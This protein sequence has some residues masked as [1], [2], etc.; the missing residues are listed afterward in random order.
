M[1][2]LASIC[3][4]SFIIFNGCKKEEP[5]PE[6]VATYEAIYKVTSSSVGTTSYNVIEYLDS[7]GDTVRSFNTNEGIEIRFPISNK[8]DFYLKAVGNITGVNS[9]PDNSISV[10]VVRTI[11]G[12]KTNF[13]G[14]TNSNIM[15]SGTNRNFNNQISGKF[16]DNSCT[17]N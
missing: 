3:I 9:A 6:P 2:N 12:D 15:G 16:E 8:K 7:K 14:K 17:F 10:T 13:C 11:E 5:T 1:K 4:L